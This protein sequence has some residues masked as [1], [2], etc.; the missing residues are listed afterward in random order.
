MARLKTTIQRR[1]PPGAHRALRLLVADAGAEDREDHAEHGRRRGQAGLED[2]RRRRRSSSRRSPARSRTSAAR[3]SRSPQFKLREGMP[4]GAVGDAAR[5]SA[6]TSSSTACCRSRSRAIR[7][8]RG[9]NPRSFDGRGNYSMG[10]REQIIF[11]E[12]DYDAVDQVR[13]L[14]VTITTTAQTDEEAYALLAGVRHAVLAREQPDETAVPAALTP[15]RGADAGGARRPPSDTA[16]G[17]LT[18][19]QDVTARAP[20][21]RA[22]STR[23]ASTRAAAAAAAPRAVYRKFGLCR[24]CLRELAHNGY[25]PGMTKSSW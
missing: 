23:P 3:A 21:A 6:P 10:V 17:G 13:G 22:A 20:G 15:R 19:G 14:D 9:L 16:R 24:I 4:V 5:A 8:F 12:I 11:P 7:D 25:I 2:A 1:D 18:H